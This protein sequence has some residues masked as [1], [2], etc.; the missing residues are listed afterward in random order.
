MEIGDMAIVLKLNTPINLRYVR[1]TQL[2]SVSKMSG[3]TTCIFC[4]ILAGDEPGEILYQDESVA[5]LKDIKPAAKYHYLAIPKKHID[6]IHK[7]STLSDYKDLV[8]K[9]VDCGKRVL[10]ENGGDL[11]DIRLGFHCPPFN[12]ISHL[13]LHIISPASEMSFITGIVF[14]PNSWWFQ[15]VDQILAKLSNG[16]NK[17]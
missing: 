14:K 3:T 6:N 10:Q 5:V 17:L 15:S 12:S 8:K 1:R 4:K 7:L 9:L 13:H 2:S 11:N 16:N